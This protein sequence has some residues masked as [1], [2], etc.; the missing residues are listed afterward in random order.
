[1]GV[2]LETVLILFGAGLL[3][4]SINNLAGAA[5][6]LGLIGLELVGRLDPV[7]ANASLRLAA[8]AI[9]LSGW[10]G[11]RSRGQSI[12]SR[13]WVYGLLTVPGAVAGALMALTLPT[14]AL[15]ITLLVI[16]LIVLAQQLRPAPAGGAARGAGNRWLAFAVFAVVGVHMGFIQVGASLL[17]IVALTSLHS[18]DLIEVN[19]AKMAVVICSSVTATTVMAFSGQIAWEPAISLAAGCGVGSFLASRWSV[20]RGH[21]AVRA[22]VLTITTAILAWVVWELAA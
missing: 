12:P 6:G 1:L 15:R 5:G 18:R 16:L 17:M 2:D 19:A 13:A 3:M 9:G 21:H 7:Q 20:D 10:L 4:G 11:F 14:T 8:I 22:V